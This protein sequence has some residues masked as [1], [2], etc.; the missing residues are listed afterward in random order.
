MLNLKRPL[1]FIDLEATGLNIAQDKIIEYSFYKVIANN[2][3][4]ILYDRVDP[5]IP[6]PIKSSKIHNIYDIDIKNKQT[7]KYHANKILDFLNN[8]DLAG[9][10]CNRFDIPILT[11][12]FLRINID[13]KIDNYKII[14]VQNIFHKME[15]RT[16]SAAYKFYCNKELIN[17]HSAKYDSMATYEVL[18]AQISKYKNIQIKDKEGIYF[19]P[20]TSNVNDLNNFTTTNKNVDLVGKIIYN[21]EGKEIFNFG[22][23]IGKIVEHVLEKDPYYYSWIM[24]SNFTLNTKKKI[25]EIKYRKLKYKK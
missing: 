2:N 17:A 21:D 22:K 20:I 14:D 5:G 7:F 1:V 10:N 18:L 12:E 8:C 3:Y 4:K 13:F 19:N 6:I 9:Y 24:K 16:L 15:P 11:E 25:T 23:Y